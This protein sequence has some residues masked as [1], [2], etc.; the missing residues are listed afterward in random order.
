M[1]MPVKVMIPT[2]LR[3]FAA[4]QE[5]VNLEAATVGEALSALTLQFGDLKKHL[6]SDDGRLRSFVNVYVNDEDIRYLQK[7]KTAVQPGDT[8]SIVPS[9]AGGAE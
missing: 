8:I 4:K 3:Q 6:Y 7:E 9:I 1:L 5:S 2:P